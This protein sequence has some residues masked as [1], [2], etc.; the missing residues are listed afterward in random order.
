MH[1]QN[2]QQKE[3][4]VE[5]RQIEPTLTLLDNSIY[6]IKIF[7]RNII[8]VQMQIQILNILVVIFGLINFY[9]LK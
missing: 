1:S 5:K 4:Q 7:T 6:M 9:L 8:W 2:S 3:K